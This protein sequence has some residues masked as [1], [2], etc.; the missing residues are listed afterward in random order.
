MSKSM[1][2]RLALQNVRKNRTT[3][4][5]YALACTVMIAMFYMI[6]G[7]QMQT[8]AAAGTFTGARTIGVFL[9]FGIVICGIFSAF[10]VFYTNGFLMKRRSREFGLYSLLGMEKKHIARVV[11]YEIVLVGLGSLI[12]GLLAGILFSRLIFLVLIKLIQLE[13][14][15]AFSVSVP[16]IVLTAVVF[17]GI[18][19]LTGLSNV[20]RVYRMKPLEL[21]HSSRTGEREPKAKWL[22]AML[23]V[24]CL[25][26]GYYIAVTTENPIKAM[27]IF[28]VAV[29]LVMAGT[30]L[31]FLSG[32]IA[33]LKLMKRSKGFYYRKNHF[34]NVSGMMYRMKQNAVGLA[35]ICILSTMV[36]VTLSSTVSLYVGMEDMLRE[37]YPFDLTVGYALPDEQDPAVAESAL[38][39]DVTAAGDTLRERAQEYHVTLRDETHYYHYSTSVA[40][41]GSRMT[42]N[43]AEVD[44]D[45]DYT[46]L[47]IL[48]VIC[49]EDYNALT[50]S[51]ETLEDGEILLYREG[52]WQPTDGTVTILDREYTVRGEVDFPLE[53]SVL[54]SYEV[55]TQCVVVKD[56]DEMKEIQ[57][58]VNASKV[59]HI[60]IFYYYNCNLDGEMEDKTAF[61]TSLWDAQVNGG[62]D[63]SSLSDIYTAREDF[64][65]IYGALLFIGIFIGTLFLITT[66]MIIYYKQVSEGYDDRERFQ[67]MQKVGLSGEETWAAIK[68][69]ILMLFFLPVLLAVVHICFAF[70]IISRILVIFEFTKVALFAICTAGTVLAFFAVYAAVYLMTA[71]SYYRITCSG[72][73]A[74]RVE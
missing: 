62:T 56:L 34:I 63:F 68:S 32:S 46:M 42:T 7:I 9:R 48:E 29:L 25:G 60:S 10:T 21:M 58:A 49:L 59:G 23:G 17:A 33:I 72:G 4:L 51:A 19:V 24:V 31:L 2:R 52:D 28:F 11:L 61:C 50:G 8:E 44:P 39:V 54:S 64:I 47:C 26:A 15:F 1:Y 5:P 40:I 38:G 6:A 13:A 27:G 74:A 70:K 57:R 53:Q 18:F 12:V 20:V 55:G 36:L 14:P 41:G 35:N 43:Y 71:K 22:L 45:W 3:F 69:Q 67:I 65:G 30:Y 37:R 73:L 66:V 16:S